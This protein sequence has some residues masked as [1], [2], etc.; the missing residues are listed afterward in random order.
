[1]IPLLAAILFLVGL[2]LLWLSWRRKKA[3]G[4][5]AGRIIYSD[6]RAGERVEEPLYDAALGL[7]G[8]PD[9][10]IEQGETLIPVEVKSGRAAEAPYD[11]HIFQL[12]AY[13]LLV[14]REYGKRPPHG[15]LRYAN[16][17]F[18]IDYTQELE[19]ALLA[20]LDEMHTQERRKELARSHEAPGRC[21]ACGYRSTCDQR[22]T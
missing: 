16:R 13:C 22:L 10:L 18:A 11:G 4:L 3:A 5:P 14:E 21:R 19:A 20:L 15:I 8:R 1:M 12:A 7:V 9:Y 17:S 6:T 2:A